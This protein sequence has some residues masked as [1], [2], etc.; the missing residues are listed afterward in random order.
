VPGGLALIQ[1]AY[2]TGTWRTRP[3]RRSYRSNPAAMTSYALPTFWT[4]AE[5]CGLTPRWLH[6]VPQ[7]EVG[8]R[9]AYVLLENTDAGKTSI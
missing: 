2:D 7:D 1:I 5:R 3:R 6:L 4:L 9:Y 8:K